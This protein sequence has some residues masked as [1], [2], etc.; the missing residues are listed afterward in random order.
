MNDGNYPADMKMYTK[1]IKAS[2]PHRYSLQSNSRRHGVTSE[3][4]LSAVRY[5]NR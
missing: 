2:Q 5:R 4:F 1:C 3:S